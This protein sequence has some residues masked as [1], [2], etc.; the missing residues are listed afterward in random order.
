M[1]FVPHIACAQRPYLTLSELNA[2]IRSTLESAFPAPLWVVAEISE[3]RCNARGHCYLELVEKEGEK[4]VAQM[5]ATIWASSLEGILSKFALATGEQLKQGMKVLLRVL[6][7]FHE[8]YGLSLQVRDVDPAYSIGEMARKKRDVIARLTKEGLLELNKA[9][10]LALVLQRI[11]VV[12]S[13]TAAGYGDFLHHIDANPD[14]YAI[15]HELYHA[16]MQGEGA[17]ASLLAALGEIEKRRH[18]Y[19]AVVIVRGGGSQVDLSCFDSYALALKVATFPLPV[20]TGIGHERDDTV[21]DIV[22][23]TRLKTPTAVAEFLLDRIRDF[24]ERVLR[25]ERACIR[26]A[27]ALLRGE[28]HRFR[29]AVQHFGQIVR[30]RFAGERQRL[31][32]TLRGFFRGTAQLLAGHGQRLAVDAR[33]LSAGAQRYLDQQDSLL[34]Q[35]DQAIRHLDPANI[36]M[37]GY[38]I[39][40]FRG[41]ALKDSSAVKEGDIIRTRVFLGSVRSRVEE[42]DVEE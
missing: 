13:A 28:L 25:A 11:A 12:S 38:S 3:M 24:E 40:Y 6:V 31:E 39:T 30:D 19:D 36:L 37:R 10:P 27:G 4:T 34:K 32:A 29:Y 42:D 7:T 33:L 17:E 15:A 22:A 9:K 35:L 18:H 26:A 5:R 20:I 41:R 2:S 14:G 16:T 21:V 8:V 1:E 23:H